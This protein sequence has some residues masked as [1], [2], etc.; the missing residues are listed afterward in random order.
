[1]IEV[2]PFRVKCPIASRQWFHA[3]VLTH[4]ESRPQIRQ[5][6]HNRI[7][8]VGAG[9]ASL[10]SAEVLTTFQSY[11]TIL[12]VVQREHLHILNRLDYAWPSPVLYLGTEASSFLSN[13][14]RRN[15]LDVKTTS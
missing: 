2:D 4:L 3:P 13:L 11:A 10:K 8:I 15:L 6:A 7:R 1:M 9:K 5:S 14:P 12:L